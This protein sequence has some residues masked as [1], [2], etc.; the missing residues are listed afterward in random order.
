MKFG[1]DVKVRVLPKGIDI[2]SY[3]TST[4]VKGKPILILGAFDN[5]PGRELL[6]FIGGDHRSGL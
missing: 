2:Q 3:I 5:S 1:F 6:V 4:S